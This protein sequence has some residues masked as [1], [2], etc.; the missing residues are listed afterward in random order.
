MNSGC[1]YF[2][3][4]ERC[5]VRLLVSLHSLRKHYSGPVAIA[6]EGNPPDWFRSIVAELKAEIIEAS[7]SGEYGLVKKSRIWRI[8]PFEHTLFLDADTLIRAPVDE[9]LQKVQEFG[10]VQTRFNDW[11]TNRGRMRRRI[12]PWRKV[13]GSLVEAAI[14]Y[15]KAINTGVQGWSR[16]HPI[17]PA[18]QDLTERGLKVKGIGRKVLDEI[19]MQ[20]L[21]PKYPHYLAGSEWNCGCAHGDGS[22]AKII[23]YHGHKHCREGANGDLWKAEFWELVKR[24]PKWEHQLKTSP[25]DSIAAWL[26][27]EAGA[28][29]DVTIVTAVNPAYAEKLKRNLELWRKTPGLSHQ[30]F[31]VFVNGFGSAKERAFLDLPNVEV[32]R[33][34]YDGKTPRETMLAAFVLGTAKHVKTKFW[35]KLDADTKPLKPFVWP[36]YSKH[37]ITSH[38]WGYTKMKGDANP[39][40]HWFT[41]LEHVF[42]AYFP[43]KFDLKRDYK[44]CHKRIAS[45]AHIERTDFTRRVANHIGDKMPIPSHD[46]L[47]WYAASIWGQPIKRMNMKEYFQP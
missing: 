3:H 7:A 44:Y 5:L 27:T 25:D 16:N 34:R 21:L 32:V 22:K 46:T 19:A 45:F 47:V 42:G 39:K 1:L 12:E 37:A 43:H 30:K 29:P 23:H 41:T 15:G 36:D 2:N 10:C 38:K 20:L 9:L 24:F 11:H 17:L 28:R 31:L 8:T 18:Y 6:A 4:G 35:M 13:D 33:W 14:A 40:E 26:A